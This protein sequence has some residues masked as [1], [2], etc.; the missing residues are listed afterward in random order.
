[1]LALLF[2]FAYMR[3]ASPRRLWL[4]LHHWRLQ[5]QL[6]GRARN[7]RVISSERPDDRFL[8]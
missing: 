6:R 1:V 2:I 7:L 4:Q 5:R 8:N 3:G